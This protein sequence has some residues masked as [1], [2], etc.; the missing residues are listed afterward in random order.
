MIR[1]ILFDI[2]GV[3]GTNGWGS[4]ERRAAAATFGLDPDAF[5]Q[6]HQEAVPTWESGHMSLDDYLDFA[7]FNVPRAF[8]RDQFRDFM[9]AQSIAMPDMIALARELATSRRYTM[10][11]LNNESAELNAMR[12]DRFELRPLFTAFLTS[13]YIG[14]RKPHGAFYDRAFAIAHADPASTVFI[15][16]RDVNLEPV[17]ERGVHTIHA[18][19]VEAVRD[20]LVALGVP[21]ASPAGGGSSAPPASSTLP[22]Y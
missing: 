11:T 21:L 16:D 3:L 13:C 4:G 8:T 15:D 18:T 2:G 19:S 9:F 22:H 5:E 12:I 1:L 10:M 20:G 7:V 6:R 14:F 17:R